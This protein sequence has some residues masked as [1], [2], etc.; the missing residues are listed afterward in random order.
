M[1]IS[2]TNPTAVTAPTVPDTQPGT[3]LT[4]PPVAAGRKKGPAR[5]RLH[6][7]GTRVA[8]KGTAP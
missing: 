4:T 5:A 6:G 2:R 8:A 7:F 1:D 3:G